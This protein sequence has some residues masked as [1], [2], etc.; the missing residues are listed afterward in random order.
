MRVTSSSEESNDM[1]VTYNFATNAMFLHAVYLYIF[2]NGYEL[3]IT[4]IINT[5]LNPYCVICSVRQINIKITNLLFVQLAVS[6]DINNSIYYK[7]HIMN[8]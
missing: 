1:I 6:H 8:G 4:F 2:I 3:I 7:M 5:N